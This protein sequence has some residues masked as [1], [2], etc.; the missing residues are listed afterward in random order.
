MEFPETLQEFQTAFPDDEACWEA[1]RRAR[2]P[3]GFVCSPAVGTT[4]APGSP[5][6]VSSS[7]VVA[8][9]SAR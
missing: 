7:V 5:P 6:D 4:K 8:V 1:V 3:E 9:T 2:W